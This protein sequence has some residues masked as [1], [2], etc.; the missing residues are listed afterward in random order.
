MARKILTIT[1]IFVITAT[2][3]YSAAAQSQNNF[4]Q[5]PIINITGDEQPNPNS[6]KYTGSFNETAP[7]VINTTPEYDGIVQ[8]TDVFTGVTSLYDMASNTVPQ[9]IEMQYR[10][11]I[12]LVFVQNNIPGL[13]SSNRRCIYVIS[14]NAGANWLS[15]GVV[16]NV[17]SGFPAL[18]LFSDG[19]AVIGMHGTIGGLQSRTVILHDIAPLVG[20]FDLCDPGLLPGSSSAWT[21]LVITPGDKVIFMASINSSTA[22]PSTF[23]NTLP[24]IS[25]CN[26]SGW[27]PYTDIDNAEQYSLAKAA[28]GTIGLIYVSRND[29]VPA[30]GYDVKFM[31][32]TDNGLTWGTPITIWNSQPNSTGF[33][34]ALR[35]V[36][37]IYIGNSPKAVFD[38][39]WQTDQNTYFPQLNGRI[40]FW[41]PN[42]NG[43]VP[44]VLA[45]STKVPDRPIQSP[46]AINDV[47]INISRASIGKSRDENF[48]FCTFGV[49]KVQVSSYPDST[50]FFDVYLA[51]APSP[52]TDW[53]G[54]DSVTNLSGPVRDCRYPNIAPVNDYEFL[55]SYY[56]NI[57]YIYD[58]VP[59]TAINGAA[60]SPAQQHFLR[61]KMNFYVGIGN[62]EYEY[63]LTFDLKQNY[64][65]PFNPVTKI[66]FDIPQ[67]SRFRGNDNVILKIY[68][69]LGKEITTLVNEQFFPGTYE[70]EWN[71]GDLPSGVYYYELCSGNYFMAK[72][73]VL[74]K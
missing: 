56:A 26:F 27:M 47:Y 2:L 70:V 68:D 57:E 28:N 37:L 48:L 20:V 38:L 64:P 12:N 53:Y 62:N 17:S 74:I 73:M 49:S 32:S 11:S 30:N 63:P 65:N 8:I 33:L 54:Y 16:N 59:G 35:G 66:R 34:G 50:P 23:I 14:T 19:R 51:W 61:V 72:K 25:P 24:G 15:L 45:D 29:I 43:G 10:D 71:A 9:H 31:E 44:I 40:M 3:F 46:N 58:A 39:G 6:K 41:S 36:D 60:E 13:P 22:N 1:E 4:I 5:K 52:G 69:I 18:G 67:D 7:V 42:V 55:N 21:K